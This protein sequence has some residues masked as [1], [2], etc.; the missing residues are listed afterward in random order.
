VRIDALRVG[1]QIDVPPTAGPAQSDSD[2]RDTDAGHDSEGRLS[3]CRAP[4]RRVRR[5]EPPS[6]RGNGSVP[7]RVGGGARRR[8]PAPRAS[9]WRHN[10]RLRVSPPLPTLV[11]GTTPGRQQSIA[12][13]TRNPPHVFAWPGSGLGARPLRTGPGP[14]SLSKGQPASIAQRTPSLRGRYTP[15]NGCTKPE[16]G[17]QLECCCVD[18]RLGRGGP[19]GELAPVLVQ[20]P[21][22]GG[23]R[24]L[25]I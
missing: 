1:L 6:R 2:G 24:T 21:P 23:T 18:T 25:Y 5:S 16:P 3:S 17:L 8:V 7:G 10:R 14:P 12:A 13:L 15:D 19:K 20:V 22:H 4:Q 11:P 9:G